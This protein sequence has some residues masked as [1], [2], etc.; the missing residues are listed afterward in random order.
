V[1]Y[2]R[3][4][5]KHLPNAE[6][7]A[8]SDESAIKLFGEHCKANVIL[9]GIN[10]KP[11]LY[12]ND[13]QK[14]M[15]EEFKI[16]QDEKVGIVVARLMPIKNYP[17]I[18]RIIR[19]GLQSEFDKFFIVGDG[20]ERSSIIKAIDEFPE[21][22]KNKI[23]FLGERMDIARLLIMSDFFVLTSFTEGLSISVI[24]AQ[25][26]GLGVAASDGIPIAT[27]ITNKVR[28]LSVD[29]SDEE[30]LIAIKNILNDKSDRYEMNQLVAES[31]FSD[32][33]FCESIE[34]LY[35]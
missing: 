15:R 12:K 3:F 10:T 21:Q 26:S 35:R 19:K 16:S 25:A 9:N 23:Y 13:I 30:W 5:L 22:I 2:S 31:D 20:P 32:S 1:P 33:N 11:F 24:E 17:K 14:E 18:L 28:F 8:V 6:L 34:K 27:N 7:V 29:E 4:Q